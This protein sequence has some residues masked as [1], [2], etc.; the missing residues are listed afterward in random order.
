MMAPSVRKLAL[1]AHLSTSVGWM[2]AAAAFLSLA[3]VGLTAAD[4]LVVRGAYVAM[5]AVLIYVVVPIAIGS[6]VSGLVSS[7]GT[8]WGLFR[9]YWILI[10]LALTIVAVLVLLQ[11]LEPIR[12]LS[13]A[14]AKAST[15]VAPLRATQRPLVHAG[16]GIIVLLLIQILGVY[17]PRGLTAYEWRRQ[18]SEA[19]LR[20]IVADAG[21]E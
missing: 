6:L 1:L 17:K 5:N 3:V 20:R 4:P 18:T 11:Q 7:L 19:K 15:S 14:A 2:G 9:H 13:E 10:K 16:G 21:D 12:V 8:H